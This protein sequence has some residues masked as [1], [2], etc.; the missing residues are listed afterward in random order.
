MAIGDSNTEGVGVN[1]NETWPHQ[2]SKLIPNG[3]DLNFGLAGA[4]N[5]YIARTLL[6]YYD[7][8]KP[9]LVLIMYTEPLR[10]E[11]YTKFGGIHPFSAVNKWGYMEDTDDGKEIQL[12]KTLLNNEN[13]D[14]I[15]W[16]KN[17]LLIK[18]FLEN[19]KCNWLWNGWFGISNSYKEFN[20]F[21][22]EYGWICDF[23]A[24]N[25]HPGVE[26]NKSYS[27]KLDTWHKIVEEAQEQNRRP[28]MFVR[29]EDETGKHTLRRV[30]PKDIMMESDDEPQD[31]TFSDAIHVEAKPDWMQHN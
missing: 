10:R 28:C 21:D 2:L 25:E 20:R 18:H 27:F 6:T 12:Y 1:D 16:Y 31:T 24:D 13:E 26:H 4:S 29:F 14:I 17:H 30:D 15:N 8:I 3:V 11:V 7:L 9:D 22:G 5:D 23:G 19:K